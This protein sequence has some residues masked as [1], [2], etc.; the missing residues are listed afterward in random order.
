MR[1]HGLCAESAKDLTQWRKT[2]TTLKRYRESKHLPPY[3][4]HHDSPG[5]YLISMPEVSGLVYVGSAAQTIRHR[6]RQHISDLLAQRH[7]NSML[8]RAVNKYGTDK[9][10]FEILEICASDEVLQREQEWLARYDWDDLFNLNPNAASRLGAKLSEEDRLKLAESHGGISSPVILQEIAEYYRR[11][12]TQQA[13]AERYKVD[14]SSIRNYLVRLKV[15]M[16]QLASENTEL[17]AQVKELYEKGANAK[18][19]AKKAGIDH[20]TALRILRA[21]GVLRDASERQKM[22]VR[23]LGRRHYAEAAGAHIHEFQHPEH[24]SFRGYQF[25]FREKF[26]LPVSCVSQLCTGCRSELAG[27]RLVGAPKKTAN[28]DK[29]VLKVHTF[30]HPTHGEFTGSQRDFLR[31]FGGMTQAGVSGLVNGRW[32]AYKRWE[33]KSRADPHV[34]RKGSRRERAGLPRNSRRKIPLC[35]HQAI[36]AELE[37]GVTQAAIAARYGVHQGSISNLCK[38]QGWETKRS[39]VKAR[40]TPIAA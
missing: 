9:L 19:C 20:D 25:E 31:A 36:K 27:W 11:G 39:K 12:A 3:E 18:Q 21:S 2:K 33:I 32:D 24:G 35:D 40:V 5:V 30:T 28:R 10:R 26:G 7:G 38:R 23:K 22:R 29:Q 34:F 6:W 16:R 17:V 37:A 1:I 4:K 14:R 13:L 15:E 8:Q